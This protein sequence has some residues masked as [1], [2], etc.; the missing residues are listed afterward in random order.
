MSQDV[1]QLRIVSLEDSCG[2]WSPEPILVDVHDCIAFKNP[3][4]DAP[5]ILSVICFASTHV[6][7][8]DHS[9]HP[10]IAFAEAPNEALLP[11]CRPTFNGAWLAKDKFKGF[12]CKGCGL[13][14]VMV[15][16]AILKPLKGQIA[17]I[18]PQ[19]SQ[20]VE[21]QTARIKPLRQ[22]AESQTA[23][24]WSNRNQDDDE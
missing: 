17:R 13:D 9:G 21:D 15:L 11:D 3:L 18:K 5:C 8:T 4:S 19:L 10:H 1:D 16:S 6:E 24:P 12:R 14:W 7:Y 2:C 23:R 22:T 20:A